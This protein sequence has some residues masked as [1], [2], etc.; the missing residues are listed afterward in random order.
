MKKWYR[1][2]FLIIIGLYHYISAAQNT[3]CTVNPQ[4][5]VLLSV[6]IDPLTGETGL[7]WTISPSPEVGAYIVHR[8]KDGDGTPVDTIMDSEAE[9]FTYYETESKYYSLSYAISAWDPVKDC[10]SILSNFLSTIFI[11]SQIDTCRHEVRL[12]WNDF[13]DYPRDVLG[14]EIQVNETGSSSETYSVDDQ[15]TAFILNNFEVDKEYC[16]LIRA[17]LAGGGISSSGKNCLI[18]SMTRPPEWINADFATVTPE[19]KV[20]L[21]YTI[22]PLS[23]IKRFRLEKKTGYEGSF[24]TV[25][26]LYSD[27]QILYVDDLSDIKKINFYRLSAVNNCDPP[28]ITSNISSN[29]V[30]RL[31]RN[32]SDLTL[33]WN[34]Y[35]SWQG[36]NSGYRLM[37]NKGDGYRELDSVQ[38]SDTSY[39]L[40]YNEI[41]SDITGNE[42]CFRIIANEEGNPYGLNGESISG[43]ACILNSEVITVPDLFTPDNDARNDFFK[44][45]LSFI[46]VSFHLI[47]SDR[48]GK[49]VFETTSNTESWDGSFGGNPLP[50]DVYLWF[51]KTTGPSGKT[52]TKTGTITLYR[53]R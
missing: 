14:Y 26:E 52:F 43:E 2:V 46:P 3:D 36:S 12:Q 29:I 53:N 27:G 35:R 44:P 15:T 41:M 19:E 33:M 8:F 13:E 32:G 11:N 4:P 38:P 9:K 24:G 20:M 45:V 37:I 50:G 21:S 30:P 18:T 5:P 34:S 28:V 7:E 16:F 47:V 22:D 48:R 39:T 1:F 25:A 31:T 10:E 49:V 42:V 51:L 40:S 23:E 6:S 17:V